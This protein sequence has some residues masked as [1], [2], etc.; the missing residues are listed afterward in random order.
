MAKAISVWPAKRVDAR[1]AALAAQC[2]QSVSWCSKVCSCKT[3]NT[4]PQ[5]HATFC[6]VLRVL[7]SLQLRR[8]RLS[9]L[10]FFFYSLH[11]VTNKVCYLF[12]IIVC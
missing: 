11:F 2:V 4:V 3:Q 7:F 5:Q 10:P 6:H 1:D 12:I 9:C 8:F